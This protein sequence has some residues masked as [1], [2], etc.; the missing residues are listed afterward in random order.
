MIVAAIDIGTNTLLLLVAEIDEHG[1]MRQ[2][3][4]QQRLP[5]LGKDVDRTGAIGASAFD[6]IA[7]IVQ[8]YKHLAQ[9][10]HADRIVACATSAVRDASNRDEFRDFLEKNT[11]IAVEILSGDEEAVLAYRGA[12]SGI[13]RAGPF[14][15]VDIGGGSTQL[16]YQQPG[17]GNGNAV[18]HRFSLQIGAVRLTERNF[19]H[20]PP[21]PAEIESARV[22]SWKK[23]LRFAIRDSK[24]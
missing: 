2:L 21:L 22:S 16:I 4:H 24:T 10:L 3:E 17:G 7:W 23:F 6:R 18:L 14:V 19:K 13:K 9:Q 5:R 8:E 12:L 20:D 11:G 1:T 15:V